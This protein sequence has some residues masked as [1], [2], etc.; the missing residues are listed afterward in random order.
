MRLLFA[1]ILLVFAVAD[2]KRDTCGYPAPKLLNIQINRGSLPRIY[3]NKNE[4]EKTVSDRSD[5]RIKLES[6]FEDALH[7]AFNE[8]GYIEFFLVGSSNFTVFIE[9]DLNIVTGFNTFANISGGGQLILAPFKVLKPFGTTQINVTFKNENLIKTTTVHV[10]MLSLVQRRPPAIHSSLIFTENENA[11]FDA[12]AYT[13]NY[14]ELVAAANSSPEQTPVSEMIPNSF[15]ISDSHAIIEPVPSKPEKET[16]HYKTLRLVHIVMNRL[17]SNKAEIFTKDTN[18]FGVTIKKFEKGQ[19]MFKIDGDGNKK[20][21]VRS[22]SELAFQK[23]MDVEGEYAV[24]SYTDGPDYVAEDR[25]VVKVQ[26]DRDE[27]L[28]AYLTITR[29]D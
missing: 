15:N 5:S 6:E 25:L 1:A 4:N 10:T 14:D 13:S 29:V 21:T 12:L 2:A 19:I 27:T 23:V 24:F 16:S 7:F 28:F 11:D 18:V 17:S 3:W 20:V 26:N 8:T 22:Y 9:A